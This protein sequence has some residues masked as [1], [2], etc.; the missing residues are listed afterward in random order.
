MNTSEES[1]AHASDE[2]ITR[3]YETGYH[4]VPSIKEAELESV[5]GEIRSLIERVGGSFIAEGAPSL[6]KLAYSMPAVEG[7]RRVEYDRGYFGWLKF[8]ATTSAAQTIAKEII[9]NARI[10][11]GIV[12]KTVREDTR[13]KI[14]T[15]LREV[16]RTDTIKVAPRREVAASAPVSEEELDK[17]IETLTLE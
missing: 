4:L 12:F 14:K 6:V 13:A 16:K 3:I 2:Q 7:G 1:N 9:A 17:A 15:S 10:L 5:V 11:R 8:E